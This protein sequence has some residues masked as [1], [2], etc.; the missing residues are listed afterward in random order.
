M[1]LGQRIQQLRKEHNLSQETLGE[2]LG[3][4]RQAISKWES[5]ITIPEI[6]KL[7]ALSRLFGVS[8]GSLLGVEKDDPAA[9]AAEELTDRELLAVE[10]IVGRYLEKAG[11]QTPKRKLWPAV[12][13]IATAF[14]LI[15]WFKG[16]LENLNGRLSSL[17]NNVNSIDSSVSRQIDSMADQIQNLLEEEASLLADFR[18][19]VTAVDIPSGTLTMDVQVTPKNYT[20]GMELS[21][22]AELMGADPVTFSGSPSAGHS[23]RAEGWV[24]PLNDEIRLSAAFGADGAWQTQTLGTLVNWDS[25]TTLVV[26]ASLHENGRLT[27]PRG[28]DTHWVSALRVSGYFVHKSKASSLAGVTAVDA[29]L[30]LR[31]NGEP[32]QSVPLTL[33]PGEDIQRFS[34]DEFDASTPVQN[35]DE[36]MYLLVYRDNYGRTIS[37]ELEG[38]GFSSASDGTLEFIRIAP[39]SLSMPSGSS[40][41]Y[42]YTVS[43]D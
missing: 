27:D 15:L 41:D 34:C 7:I 19:E 6:D 21:F 28:H 40:I 25:N 20:E 23:F 24:I 9:P 32:V 12:L 8:V 16:Q 30:E 3:V 1:T 17:Q 31:R 18:Y 22:T 35:G 39:A 2:Q 43:P 29:R 26:D 13:A 38:I 5:D 33:H 42:H 36:L 14:F 4:S 37:Q 11:S 10:A